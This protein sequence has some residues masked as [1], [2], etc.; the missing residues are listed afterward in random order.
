MEGGS[1]CRSALLVCKQVY[2]KTGSILITKNGSTS[3][4]W[5]HHFATEK[6]SLCEL[7]ILNAEEEEGLYSFHSG[8]IYKNK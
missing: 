4:T 6:V 3:R 1:I 2:W 8:E 7:N 5:R